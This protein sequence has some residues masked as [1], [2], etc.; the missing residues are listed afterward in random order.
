[1]EEREKRVDEKPSTYKRK[2]QVY[3]IASVGI[4]ALLLLINMIVNIASNGK[5][6]KVDSSQA[7]QPAQ[8][9][10][11]NDPDRFQNLLNN[12]RHVEEQ[13][14]APP[15][16]SVFDRKLNNGTQSGEQEGGTS[17]SQGQQ[18][19]QD[20]EKKLVS[21]VEARFKAQE[22]E[23]ALKARQTHYADTGNAVAKA[24]SSNLPSQDFGGKNGNAQ[25]ISEIDQQQSALRSRIA[26]LQGQ[27]DQSGQQM[28]QKLASAQAD[29][30]AQIRESR[31]SGGSIGQGGFGGGSPSSMGK[32][33][34]NQGDFGGNGQDASNDSSQDNVVGYGKDNLYNASTEG[35]IKLPTGAE[36]NAITTYT[37]IS[38]YTGGSMKAMITNDVLDASN[39]YVLFPKGSQLLIKVVRASGVNEVIQNRLAFLPQWLIL[40]NGNRVDF[41]KTSVLD[42]M[43]TPAVQGDEVDRH[44]LAQILGVTAYA[45]VGTK[46]SYEGTGDGNDSF[47]GNF[48]ESA[49]QLGSS[50]AQKYLQIVPTI[51]LHAGAP[52]RILVEDEMFIKPWKTLYENYVD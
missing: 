40:P 37:A 45:L 19:V 20:R 25:R 41:R 7:N 17:S 8:P 23:R 3:L 11:N 30:E 13:N 39:S 15:R 22:V 9:Q 21:D 28:G 42:R 24:S 16:K 4:V 32:T 2:G 33:G 50:A 5:K 46:T 14:A 43:G 38:D 18:S 35:K 52:I 47:A 10:V 48:G 12:Q 34:G 1:M 29:V 36:I 26:M 51:K 44:I 6:A 49:R 27:V 31:S